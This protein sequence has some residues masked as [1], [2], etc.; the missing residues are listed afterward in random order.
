MQSAKTISQP[1]LL[2]GS[3]PGDD[4]AEVF[5][6]CGPILGSSVVA[7][8]DGETGNRRIWVTF[9]AAT[10]LD[11]HPH[12][13]A[14]NRP[15]P[16]GS[17]ENEW[18]T[19]GED[20]VPSSFEDLWFF[21]VDEHV[22]AVTID[23]LGYAEHALQSYQ[24]FK[25]LKDTGLISKDVRFQVCLPLA[26][27]ALRWFLSD[28]RSYDIVA[29]AYEQAL[30]V[31][32]ARICAA[33]PH[34]ELC[35]Q[36]DVCMEVIATELN[37]FSGQPP[38][39]YKLDGAPVE[40]WLTALAT[41]SPMIPADVKLGLHLCYGDLGHVH[42]VE[43]KD[44]AVSVEMANKGC[45]GA[46]RRVDYVHM[47]VP[48][49]RND[50]AYFAPLEDLDISSATPYLGLVHHTDGEAGTRDRIAAAKKV[51]PRFG[52]ATECGFGRRPRTQ[53]PAL[54]DIHKAVL[55]EL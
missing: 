51:L 1:I 6:L 36:W 55:D 46:G 45:S 29:A 15:K 12:I 18:R 52:I 19:A 5:R 11:A 40:R 33:I 13:N 23:S 43:P 24:K 7:L 26:E 30:G 2:V 48:R 39:A 14:I 49:E 28:R 34:H 44:L 35:I 16:L 8:P 27:S 42:M 47:A 53:I 9:L 25:E 20:W 32:I 31:E 17:I 22:D 50:A 54:L 37:D 3:I 41:F 38:L 21:R 10:V 4:A